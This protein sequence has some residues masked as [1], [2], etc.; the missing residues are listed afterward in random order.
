LSR[1]VEPELAS[2]SVPGVPSTHDSEIIMM[3][4]GASGFLDLVTIRKAR[5]VLRTDGHL[6]IEDCYDTQVCKS[7]IRFMDELESRDKTEVNY[8]GTE[9]RIWDAHKRAPLLADFYR[10]CNVF[11][12]CLLRRDTEALT[13]LAIR[14]NALD[15]SDEISRRGR[16]HIDSFRRQLKIFLF[17]TDTTE[18][19]GP[20]EFIPGTHA[21]TFKLG[22]LLGGAYLKAS[23]PFTGRRAYQKLDDDWVE[24]LSAKGYRP[25]SVI[26]K[27]GTMMVADTS[28]IH[29]ARPCLEGSRYALTT[30]YP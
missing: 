3:M 7:V 22:G 23:D 29:R 12:S 1:I 14:N 28:A 8:A 16:W 4:N 21:R 6:L 17:L 19:S 27:A 20:F 9:L 24:S 10:E 25:V 5:T 18:A 26:C 2:D 13:L 30:Y 11:L 15:P